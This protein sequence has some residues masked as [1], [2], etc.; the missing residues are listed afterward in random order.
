MATQRSAPLATSDGALPRLFA[1]HNGPHNH[2]VIRNDVLPRT[3]TTWNTRTGLQ[4][5]IDCDIK[6]QA[7]K[8]LRRYQLCSSKAPTQE[9][10][11]YSNRAHGP[12]TS[13]ARQV[14]REEKIRSQHCS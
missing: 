3:T 1:T 10:V 9:G 11:A 8:T 2:T 12:L 4:L 14:R 13:V 6:P 7:T 5:H